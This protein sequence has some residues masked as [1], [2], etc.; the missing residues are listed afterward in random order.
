V[1]FHVIQ[2]GVPV[3]QIAKNF[4]VLPVKARTEAIRGLGEGGL[5]V[6]T[7][8]RRS[9]REQMNVKTMKAVNQRTS[10]Y[11]NIAGLS[12]HIKA[13]GPGLPI[14]NFKTS[15]TPR[16]VWSDPWGNGR[17]FARSFSSGGKLR[18]R[19]GATRFPIRSLRG[20]SPAK[21]LVKDR[22]QVTFENAG[23][24]IILPIIAHRLG[25]LGF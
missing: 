2:R 19:R 20:P 7:M 1:S 14:S 13:S 23:H 6:R 3:A 8:V 24:S 4:H 25:K 12:F 21:E 17:V 16:G 10:S 22:T 11:L 15:V 18:A 9:L 5:R